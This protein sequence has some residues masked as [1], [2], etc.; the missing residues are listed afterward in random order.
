MGRVRLPVIALCAGLAVKLPLNFFLMP[1]ASINMGGA[2]ISTIA[3]GLVAAV[4]NLVFLRRVTGVVPEMIGTFAKPAVAAAGMG[5][6][7]FGAYR[8]TYAFTGN[9]IATLVAMGLGFVAYVIILGLMRGFG[10]R[11][12]RF[13]PRRV[14]R[15]FG[16]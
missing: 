14:R 9:L 15:F 13:L 8:L 16:G 12:L 6:V 3:F 2:I 7:C 10:E 4:V 5:V 1:I 11:E